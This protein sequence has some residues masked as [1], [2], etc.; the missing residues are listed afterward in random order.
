MEPSSKAA[1]PAGDE[2][3]V[4]AMRLAL[5][6]VPARCGG[7]V[8]V[9]VRFGLGDIVSCL[10]FLI[11]RDVKAAARLA[12]PMPRTRCFKDKQGACRLLLH[13]WNRMQC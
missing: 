12:F 4:G 5:E 9:R 3:A 8:S 13:E 2:P 7:G 6:L 10:R 11:Y 1:L